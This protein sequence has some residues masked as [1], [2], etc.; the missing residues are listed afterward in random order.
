MTENLHVIRQNNK[1]KDGNPLSVI[2]HKNLIDISVVI[3]V[4]NE[5]ESLRSCIDIL[6]N[7]LDSTEKEY[8]IIIAEDGS[9]DGTREL[10]EKMVSFDERII[11]LHSKGRLGRG[12]AL[13]NAFKLS[14]GKILI[15]MDVDLATDLKHLEEL[16]SHVE[17]GADFATG[18]RLLKDSNTNRPQNREIASQGY[19]FLVRLFFDIPIHDMQCGFK[20]FK[21]NALMDI[22]DDIEDNHWFWDTECFIR[23]HK[24]GYAIAEFPV[25]WTHKGKTKVNLL[26]DAKTM[27][28]KL[29]KLWRKMDD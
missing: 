20:A 23:A 19:N 14:Y 15:Y 10:A 1:F 25:V 7:A 5:V 2:H 22:L 3:P 26:H 8:E 6:K 18:S 21:R 12:K 4:Y 28:T 27:G 11:L 24:K 17:N 9:T 29:I 13:N 16:I